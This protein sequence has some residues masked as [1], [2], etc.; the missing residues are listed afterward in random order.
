MT[1]AIPALPAPVPQSTDPIN[2]DA[3]ADAFLGAL[4]ATADAMNAQNAENN[5]IN[6]NVNSKRDELMAAGL[7]SAAAHAVQAAMARDQALAGLGAADQS[8]NLAQLAGG[9]AH[10]VDLLGVVIKD[11][12]SGMPDLSGTDRAEALLLAIA[13]A[14]D[15]AGLAAR[16][17][18]GGA[19]SL[20]PGT[21]AIPSCTSNADATSGAFFPGVGALAWSTAGLERLRLTADGRLGLGTGVPSCSLDVNSDTLRLRTA[22]TPATATAAGNTGDICWNATHLFVCTATDTWRRVAIAAW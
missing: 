4:P 20:Q 16:A 3:R 12:S 9:I 14:L 11:A 1:V 10:T 18:S 13:H 5:S 2:F 17:I 21:A 22:R 19:V 8:I 7:A 6:A 15:L